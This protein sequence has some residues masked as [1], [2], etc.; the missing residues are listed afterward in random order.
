MQ[1]GFDTI[2]ETYDVRFTRSRI[3]SAQRDLVHEYLRSA[4]PEDGRLNILELACGTGED[5]LW[6][7]RRGCAVTATDA[8]SA[9]LE[10]AGARLASAGLG[11]AVE[12]KLLPAQEALAARGSG[13]Y[14]L[15]FSNFGGLNC[16]PP[17]ALAL[18]A[19]DLRT[20]LKPAGR[21]IVV[22]MPR[23]CAWETLYFLL[24]GRPASAFRRRSSGGVP[25]DLGGS[26]VTT[27]YHSPA[28]MANVLAPAFRLSARR[29]VGFFIPP[30][31]LEPF[32]AARPGL[33]RALVS[34]DRDV[35]GWPLLASGA[36]HALLDFRVNA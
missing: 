8:S 18:L 2:A 6:F 3:G 29:P 31:Y 27:W 21:L 30:S 22:V 14:D 26:V 23:F 19:P 10:A 32:V 36:D 34:M 13:P 1:H 9:M 24:K 35:S 15:I 20:L 16:L 17:A 12:L 33:F 28:S 7:A 11:S 25:A 5:A 4:L